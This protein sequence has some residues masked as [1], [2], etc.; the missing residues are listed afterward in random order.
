[1][2]VP[3]DRELEALKVLWRQGEATVRDIYDQINAH[4]GS[5]AYTTVL[6][7]LQVMEQKGLVGHRRLGKAYVH[8]AKVEREPTFRRLA[9][10][11]LQRVFDGAVD[12]YLVHAL[13]S[14]RLSPDELDRLEM[15]ADAKA[16]SK[17][18]RE[19]YSVERNSFRSREVKR[20]SF[21]WNGINSALRQ[22]K[23]HLAMNPPIAFSADGLVRW[24][25][26]FYLLATLLLLIAIVARRWIGQPAHRLTVAWLVAAELAVL[27]V[28]CALPSWPRFSLVAPAAN[29]TAVSLPAADAAVH[30]A[31]P[32]HRPALASRNTP[33]PIESPARETPPSAA[34]PASPQPSWTWPGLIAAAFLYRGR[35][36]GPAALLGGRRGRMDLP[37]G[38]SCAGSAASRLV[39]DCRRPAES[40]AA[41]GESENQQRGGAGSAAADDPLAGRVGRRRAAADPPRG[42]GPRMGPPAQPRPVALG[43]G[44]LSAGHALRPSVVLVAAVLRAA[45]TRSVWPTP[46]RPATQS[47]TMP[48]SCSVG[49]AW[50]PPRRP[51]VSGRPSEFGKTPRNFPGE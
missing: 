41:A 35:A 18:R 6:S 27:A 25:A 10:G 12:E 19:K 44:P 51:P 46:W 8:F 48:P 42:P 21:R 4:G 13:Q 24:L 43:P 7:L 16:Q 17:G 47:P 3:T 30:F 32:P 39:R 50:G 36:G 49:S 34:S 45:T 28:V 22:T 33:V 20:N 23:R 2:E 29:E 1:M 31:R 11:F 38:R 40:S 26:D 15:I 5:L 37:P 14:R 9:G